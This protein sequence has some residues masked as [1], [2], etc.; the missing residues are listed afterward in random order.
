MLL[1]LAFVADRM[2]NWN[3]DDLWQSFG[4]EFDCK[5]HPEHLLISLMTG[6]TLIPLMTCNLRPT[7]EERSWAHLS[8]LGIDARKESNHRVFELCSG[9]NDGDEA[10]LSADGFWTDLQ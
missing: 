5:P 4:Y 8:L 3:L 1:T 7:Q 6:V 10:Q 2:T 9:G